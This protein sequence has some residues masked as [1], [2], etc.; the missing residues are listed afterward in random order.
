M[1]SLPLVDW[2]VV[3]TNVGP[4]H[5]CHQGV[6][7]WGLVSNMSSRAQFNWTFWS[8]VHLRSPK[9]AGPEVSA[10]YH[11]MYAIM[12]FKLRYGCTTVDSAI[13]VNVV[14]VG[15][16]TL[17]INVVSRQFLEHIDGYDIS[18]S[19]GINCVM[20][21]SVLAR[22]NVVSDD[23][24]YKGFSYCI[25]LIV[26]YLNHFWVMC[27]NWLV[28]IKRHHHH[29]D[30]HDLTLSQLFCVEF[31]VNFLFGSSLLLLDI[32]D[33]KTEKKEKKRVCVI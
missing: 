20:W 18:I 19:T 33:G 29:V 25:Y 3:Y 26:T 23:D 4:H 28:D 14:H 6:V 7:T 31:S 11:Q 16:T 5:W 15:W 9:I 2:Q 12:S 1:M 27:V 24:S 17:C 30:L 13:C 22:T 32:Q 21:S 8:L 10:A